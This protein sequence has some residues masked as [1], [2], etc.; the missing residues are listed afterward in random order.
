MPSSGT[1]RLT[2]RIREDLHPRARAMADSMGM[3]LNAYINAAVERD[4]D[5]GGG[6]DLAAAREHLS[7]LADALG[8]V[9][10]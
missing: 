5:E 10:E 6:V 2:L 1:V 9:L 8:G 7:N 3:S 4:I